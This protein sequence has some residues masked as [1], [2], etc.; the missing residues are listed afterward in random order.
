MAEDRIILWLILVSAQTQSFVCST[1]SP[2]IVKI[3]LDQVCKN[4]FFLLQ[5][6]SMNL[7]SETERRMNLTDDNRILNLGI[8]G[9]VKRQTL[10]NS[11]FL[12]LLLD[13]AHIFTQVARACLCYK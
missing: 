8:L 7:K 2:V 6:K 12:P 4:I 5:Y 11:P 13:F 3:Y 10:L 9:Q 1:F